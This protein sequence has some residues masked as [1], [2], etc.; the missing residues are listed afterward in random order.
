M[1]ST[2]WGLG[3][4]FSALSVVMLVK[5]AA[6]VGFVSALGVIVA[7][8]EETVQKLFGWAEPTIR[9]LFDAW[10]RQFGWDLQL[11]PHWKHVTVLFWLYF[12][13]YVRT[14]AA[15][16]KTAETGKW[17]YRSELAVIALAGGL[18]AVV[19]GVLCGTLALDD[20]GTNLL[21]V[22]LTLS[23]AIVFEFAKIAT[24][25]VGHSWGL[26][27]AWRPVFEGEFDG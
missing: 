18:V 22:V 13:A 21:V 8:Y 1:K 14:R 17:V 10:R 24:R 7:F 6:D 3:L 20:P 16:V 4:L 26:G 25:T 27:Y 2:L 23:G 9:S 5:Q 11:R 15:G 12:G 19:V